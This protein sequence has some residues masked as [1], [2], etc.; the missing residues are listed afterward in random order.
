VPPATQDI[1][2][3]TDANRFQEYSRTGIMERDHPDI[4]AG[5]MTQGAQLIADGLNDLA[6]QSRLARQ[7]DENRRQPETNKTPQDLFPAG[8]HKIMRWCQAQTEDQLPQ[9][10]TDL[11]QAKKGNRR[12][13]IQ[14]AVT[15]AMETLG[16]D[17]DFPITT[18]ITSRVVDLEW[19]HQ[20][21]DDLSLGLHIFTL[22]WLTAA[23]T[24]DVKR[25]VNSVADAM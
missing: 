18:K 7:S 19:A 10:Y 9:I 5:P 22:G 16:Y 21:T 4:R 23:E 3:L 11:A 12:I 1:A 20:L 24:E 17:Q 13:T 25:L 8:L 2:T 6:T 15:N 14:A